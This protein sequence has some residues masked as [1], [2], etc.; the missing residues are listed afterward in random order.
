MSHNLNKKDGTLFDVTSIQEE[1]IMEICVWLGHTHLLGVLHYTMRES[2]ILFQSVDVMESAM[3]GAIKA[4]V[5]YNEPIAVGATNPSK[6]H[7]KA[8]MTT[9]GGE[10]PHLPPGNP[11]PGGGTPH[12]LQVELGDLADLELCQLL[13]DLCGEVTL[14]ELN[15]PPEALHQCLGETQLGTGILMQMT[16]RS[17]F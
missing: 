13:E 7:L 17:P 15:A 2:I 8:Y 12:H 10:E 6:T 16:R 5:L 3:H 4:M 14:C 9:V 1:D 11:H